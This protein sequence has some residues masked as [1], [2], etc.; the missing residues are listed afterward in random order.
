ME[1]EQKPKP[2][3]LMTPIE[4]NSELRQ[5]Y[6]F[7]PSRVDPESSGEQFIEELSRRTNSKMKE[8][9]GKKLNHLI[10]YSQLTTGGKRFFVAHFLYIFYAGIEKE[11]SAQ[12]MSGEAELANVLFSSETGGIFDI[13]EAPGLEKSL[14]RHALDNH[15][16][17]RLRIQDMVHRHL[18][19]SSGLEDKEKEVE[20]R[21]REETAERLIRQTL[22]DK[23]LVE[24]KRQEEE[25][26]AVVQD[27]L[28]DEK[29]MLGEM[30]GWPLEYLSKY[31]EEL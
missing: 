3:E 24:E 11:V 29:E 1:K 25:G 6:S 17:L 12:Q 30:K 10:E 27:L 5:I 28:I 18:S 9:L 8:G 31:G 15:L 13:T 23:Q 26:V 2:Y 14:Y 7:V 20:K 19:S 16:L 4:L 21:I 22:S